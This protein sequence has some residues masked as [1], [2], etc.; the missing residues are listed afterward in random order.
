MS[1]VAND[2]LSFRMATRS[3][4]DAIVRLLAD[5]SIGAQRESH[6]SPLPNAYYDA[7]AAIDADGN[8][9]LTVAVLD[10]RVVGVAQLTFI[11]YLTHH[12]SWRALIEG[13]RVDGSV[14]S[15]GVGR[16]LFE[17]L[18]QQSRRR[19]CQTVQLTSDKRRSDAI[20]FYEGLGFV[21]SHEGFKLAL[22]TQ[23]LPWENES[24]DNENEA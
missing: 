3:D 17:W 1:P 13:V 9:L 12:G 16:R 11:P 5:D 24:R 8:N 18:I 10:E 15:A 7:F 22:G 4:L 6:I 14:R 23:R 20:R 2:T 19:G 21:A